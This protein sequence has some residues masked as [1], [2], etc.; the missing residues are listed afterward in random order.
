[1]VFEAEIFVVI[2]N[3]VVGEFQHFTVFELSAHYHLL[4]QFLVAFFPAFS[5]RTL[6]FHVKCL[7]SDATP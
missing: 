7:K 5:S 2:I 6:V 4:P 1:M 3:F